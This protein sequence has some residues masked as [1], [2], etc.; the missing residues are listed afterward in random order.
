MRLPAVT[1]AAWTLAAPV[2]A[3]VAATVAATVDPLIES[4]LAATGT[5]GAAFVFVHDGKILHARGY[6]V[7]DLASGAKVDPARTVWPIAS[8]SKAVTAMAVLQLVEDGRADLDTDVTRYLKRLQVPPAGMPPLTLRHLLSHT[9]GLDEL[10]G[11]QFDGREPQDLSTFLRDRIKRYRAPGE[12]TAY[13]TYGILL[14][15]LVLEDLTGERYDAYLR[16]NV[17][18]PAGMASARVMKQLGDERGV[19]IPYEIDDGRAEPMPFEWYVSAPASSIVATAEDMG[20]LLLVHLAG[21]RAGERRIL[22]ENLTQAMHEQ[23]ATVHAG[24]PGWSFGLQM[25]RVNG[26]DIA[27]HGGDIGGFSA[28]F[29]LIPEED[30]G[31]FIVNHGEGSDLRFKVKDALLDRLYPAKR[32]P[33]VPPARDEDAARLAAYTGKY[34]SSIACRSCPRTPESVFKVDA[35]PDGTLSLWGQRWIPTAPDLFIR[36]DGRRHLGFARNAAG[37]L[38]AV[39]AGSWRVADRIP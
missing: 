32:P 30:A 29:V 19:A 4:E 14:A 15:A 33:V 10:P 13:S 5:P 3:D 36:D 11:R 20:R 18:V 7:P 23:Q 37:R 39:S 25:D 28:L 6:G 31:F 9:G 26:R 38:A 16:Q 21:G 27:E 17:F 35:N 2:H 8:I 24:V 1:L 34:L 12:L 22:S